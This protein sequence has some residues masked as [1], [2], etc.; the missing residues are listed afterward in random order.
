MARQLRL[1]LPRIAMHIIQRGNNK[2]A[3]FLVEG[4]Y[5]VYLALLGDLARRTGWELHAYCLMTNHVHLLA[6]PPSREACISV[7]KNLG[8]RYVQYFNRRH[9]RTGTLWE[10]RFRSCLAESARYII[11]CYRYIEMNPVRAAMVVSPRDYMWS[12]YAGN[13]GM[14]QDPLLTPHPEF[15]AL[16][17][18]LNTR[19]DAYRS[20]FA[21][22]LDVSLLAEI[23]N[24][25][26][27]GF[28]LASDVFKASLVRGA[29]R[30]LAPGRPGRPARASESEPNLD[31]G[32]LLGEIGV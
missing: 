8:Q 4:D 6:T 2:G 19:H 30:K 12:S 17:T 21:D 9:A 15:E 31:Q 32:D 26:N 20:L 18:A 1:I 16:G 25:T 11:A 7:M 3:C 29:R 22:E 24:S 28:P 10:G 14:R 13:T 23:R 5:Q 27:A